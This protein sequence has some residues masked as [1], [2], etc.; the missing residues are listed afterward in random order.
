MNTIWDYSLINEKYIV[1][2]SNNIYDLPHNIEI[3]I[4]F[5]YFHS[6]A[7]FDTEKSTVCIR[8]N[9]YNY[10]IIKKN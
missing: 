7:I 2:N 6:K 10:A 5:C 9:T 4:C 3:D 8:G 1:T